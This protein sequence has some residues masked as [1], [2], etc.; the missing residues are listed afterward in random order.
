MQGVLDLPHHLLPLATTVA[1]ALTRVEEVFDRQLAS[2]LPPVADLVKHIEHY[3]GK[4][5]RPSLVIAVGLAS[6]PRIT[7]TPPG[8]Y[9]QLIT[10]HHHVMGA[11]LEMVHMATLVHDDV[12]DEA[13]TR[14]RGLTVNKL[15][16]NEAAVILGDYLFAAAYHLCSTLPT[17]AAALAVGRASMVTAAGELMQLHN[18][19]D[20]SIDEPTYYEIV[21]R[22]TAELIAT[23]A[24]LG[25]LASNPIPDSNA[26]D[27][28]SAIRHAMARFGRCLGIAFQIQDDLLDLVGSESVV[29]KSVHK[30]VEKGKMTLPVIHHLANASPRQRGQ[31][32]LLLEHASGDTRHA[33]QRDLIAAL[34]STNSIT[35]SRAAAAKF[36]DH[37]KHELTA[38]KDSP[39]KELLRVMADSV[40]GRAF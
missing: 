17:N 16:G 11:V 36:V 32:L 26:A 21:A 8:D 3:R 28:S 37:A 31:T 38:I 6:H 30:D 9:D 10:N 12:L 18:R 27:S 23:G 1:S 4:M 40:V 33:A 20:F 19:D 7:Q 2:D 5:L 24:E 34:E 39:A 14:R 29:G 15:R 25:V 22:K 35:M 13:D